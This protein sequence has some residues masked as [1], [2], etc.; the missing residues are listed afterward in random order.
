MS[1]QTAVPLIVLSTTRDPVEVINSALRRAGHAAHC[2]WIPALRDLG[3]ALTQLNPELILHFEPSSEDL[4]SA[5]AVRDQLAPLVPLLVVD[6]SVTE[7]RIAEAMAKGARDMV[8]SGSAE[9]L[10]AVMARELRSHRMER[11]LESTLRT[12]RDA[13]RQLA[14]VLQHS[15]DAIAQVQEGI[16][17]DANSSWLELFGFELDAI[18]GQ[19]IMDHFEQTTHAP[20]K[21]ALAACLQ[22]RW[23][24][25]PLSTEIRF[26]DGTHRQL[27]LVLALGEHDGE[28]CVQLIITS[29]KN[30][31]RKLE[32]DLADAVRRDPTTGL[33]YRTPLLAAVNEQVAAPVRGGVRYYAVVKPDKFATV[34]RDVGLSASEDVLGAFTVQVREGLHANEIIGRLG[35]TSVLVLLER[36][37]D[38]DIEAWGAQLVA[39]VARQ[40]VPVGEKTLSITCSVGLSVAPSTGAQSDSDAAIADALDA[41]SKAQ[42]R[43]GNQV[44]L[45]DK[46][47]NDTRVKA[48]DQ[49]WVKHIKAALMENRFRLVQQPIASLQGGDSA[50]FDVLL[51]MLDTN[52]KEVLPGE[53]M[54]AAERND[55]LKNI[56]RWVVGASL[57]FAAQRKPT[58]LFVRLSQ[59]TLKDG[60]FLGWIDN[61]IRATRSDPNRLCF[62]AHEDVVATHL[63]RVQKLSTELR[64]RGFKFAIE[65]FGSGRDPQGLLESTAIDFV[66]IDGA[67]VQALTSNQDLQQRV[68]ALVDQAKARNIETIAERVEDA[69]TMAVLWQLGVQ[70]IQG[71]LVH[72][73]EEIVLR[74]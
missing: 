2:T 68:R 42:S 36:G 41:C 72:A 56:D 26:A 74:S 3:D 65:R 71:Y 8:S 70:Y 34:E 30:D 20:L 29:R 17:V 61:Q 47:D 63:E 57:S 12:A 43:G 45:S 24:N 14:S 73:P 44:A 15:N 5:V 11:A 49:V 62:Q 21:G 52:G 59:D 25:H 4:V 16:L 23:S 18:A 58:C 67:L 31:A 19:P 35:G 38:H 6:D 53:F 32:E 33:L 27:D 64:S 7:V 46:A 22:G 48:Y 51:R 10:Q 9:R 37:N 60:S 39:R 69:N 50:M 66:K 54:P 13:R 28:P 1:E 40:V 55:L